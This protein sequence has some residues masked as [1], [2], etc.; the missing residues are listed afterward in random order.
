M[1]FVDEEK[2]I[3]IEAWEEES[4]SRRGIEA[5]REGIFEELE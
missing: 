1:G 3:K 2:M 4:E 5:G